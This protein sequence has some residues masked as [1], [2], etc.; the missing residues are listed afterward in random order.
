MGAMKE[1]FTELQNEGVDMDEAFDK[2]VDV[3]AVA[4]KFGS[5]SKALAFIN[6]GY[7][8]ETFNEPEFKDMPTDWV[9]SYLVGD[10]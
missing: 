5:Y 7:G 8:I 2:M 10:N 6:A 4:D 9:Y 3:I 1:I